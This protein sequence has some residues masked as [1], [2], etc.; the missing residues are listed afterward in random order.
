MKLTE[1]C[2]KL[3]MKLKFSAKLNECLT[4]FV[5]VGWIYLSF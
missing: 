1:N 4:V 2:I 3:A 5:E